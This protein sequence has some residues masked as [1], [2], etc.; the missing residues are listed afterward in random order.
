MVRT[1]PRCVSLKVLCSR[2]VTRN[3]ATLRARLWGWIVGVYKLEALTHTSAG[4]S[5][6]ANGPKRAWSPFLRCGQIRSMLSGEEVVVEVLSPGVEVSGMARTD[7]H[8][9]FFCTM[10]SIMESS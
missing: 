5:A 8:F 9:R 3:L 10:C 6:D 4:G 1:H 7:Y 2:R